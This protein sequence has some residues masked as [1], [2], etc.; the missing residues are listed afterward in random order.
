M[1]RGAREGRAAAKTQALPTEAELKLLQ[2]LWVADELTVG[3]LRERL[4]D[5]WTVGYTTILKLLQRLRDKGLVTRRANGRAHLYR[6]A[7]PQEDLEQRLARGFV[8]RAFAGSLG[9]LLQ[10]ALPEGQA[11]QGEIEE[12][13]QLLDRLED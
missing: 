8:A 2:E 13:R 7:V 10:R 5:S 4:Q 11:R 1:T 9:R 3:Q 6:S 12:I